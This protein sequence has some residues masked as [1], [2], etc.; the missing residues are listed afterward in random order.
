MQER[1]KGVAVA[2]MTPFAD[3][4]SL[5]LDG[6]RLNTRWLIQHATGEPV[7][8]CPLG[9]VGEFYAMTDDECRSVIRLVVEESAGRLLVLPGTGRAGTAET[10]RMCQ[11][12]Q[13]V[14]ANG[15][16]VILPYYLVPEEEGMYLHFKH[17]AESVDSD[18]GIVVYNNPTVSGSWIRP[19]LMQRLSKIPNIVAVKEGTPWTRSFYAMQRAVSREGLRV[20]CGI[21]EFEYGVDALYCECP[22]FFSNIANFAPQISLA[23]YNAVSCRDFD[24]AAR[25]IAVLDIYA[26]FLEEVKAKHAPHA[27]TASASTI[28]ASL[29][30]ILVG[31]AKA[32]MD[33][34]GLRGGSVRLPLTNL[35][36]DEKRRLRAVLEAMNLV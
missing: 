4:G 7:I 35:H 16:L 30:F 20:F 6:M 10:I 36:P 14:G 34:L 23:V 18:F 9:S 11:Y 13:S 29:G 21:G 27:G 17:V 12:A 8:L 25:V 1:L 5:D 19:A 32:A 2:Q 31:L 15:A 22:G 33:I 3:D 28:S 26:E 24:S